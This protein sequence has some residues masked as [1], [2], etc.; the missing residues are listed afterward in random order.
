[1]KTQLGPVWILGMPFFRYYHTTFNRDRQVM[2]FAKAG[3]DCQ[4]KSLRARDD[5]ASACKMHQC[6]SSMP[7]PCTPKAALNIDAQV[8]SSSSQ[9]Q[10]Q[11]MQHF[12]LS[13]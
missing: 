2:R 9:L 7:R 12:D 11:V 3:E 10:G 13:M 8:T 1:M 5:G 6:Q 4:P